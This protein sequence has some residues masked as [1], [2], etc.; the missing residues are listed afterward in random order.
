MLRK[1][2][3]LT[4]MVT[5]IHCSY[6][7]SAVENIPSAL[8]ENE[9]INTPSPQSLPEDVTQLLNKSKECTYWIEQWA[10][11]L[12]SSDKEKVEANVNKICLEIMD[13]RTELLQKYEGQ[14]D[15]LEYLN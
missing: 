8:I 12:N 13:Q 5:S 14:P 9:Q 10:P 1:T 4:L 6:A 2:C 7:V 15:I 11:N 3:I